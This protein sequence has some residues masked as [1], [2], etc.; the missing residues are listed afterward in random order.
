MACRNR[1]KDLAELI[2]DLAPGVCL[3]QNFRGE[4][5]VLIAAYVEDMRILTLFERYK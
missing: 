1:N 4:S 3:A 2:F 5:P